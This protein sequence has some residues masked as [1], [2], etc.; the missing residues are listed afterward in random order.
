MYSAIRESEKVADYGWEGAGDGKM[1]S[2]SSKEKE[3]FV[4]QR[5][6]T[7][8]HCSLEFKSK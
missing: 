6:R 4:R 2:V 8:V 7:S 3:N 5:I 1:K